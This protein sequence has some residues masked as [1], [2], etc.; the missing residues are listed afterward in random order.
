M[1]TR[2]HA[3][4]PSCLSARDGDSS[5]IF[6][7]CGQCSGAR[8]WPGLEPRIAR[9]TVAFR[10]SYA[11]SL[12]AAP[13]CVDLRTPRGLLAAYIV[14][15]QRAVRRHRSPSTPRGTRHTNKVPTHLRLEQHGR[16][17]LTRDWLGRTTRS[18]PICAATHP[19]ALCALLSPE[20]VPRPATAQ[21]LDTTCSPSL[22]GREGAPP[23]CGSP[24]QTSPWTAS[25]APFAHPCQPDSSPAAPSPTGTAAAESCEPHTCAL[26]TPNPCL[27]LFGA[28]ASLDRTAYCQC[29]RNPYVSAVASSLL[30]HQ[31]WVPGM[32]G[33]AV[34]VVQPF[35]LFFVQPLLNAYEAP[36]A[37][38]ITCLSFTSCHTRAAR[39]SSSACH[40]PSWVAGRFCL[41]RCS[42]GHERVWTEACSSAI[43]SQRRCA[44]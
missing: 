11:R 40:L 3:E 19:G 12:P 9:L 35:V 10:H 18:R 24:S 33:S 14:R 22:D 28:I 8:I 44:E 17:P 5:A 26:A 34:F 38:P 39:A 21:R 2:I 27:G 20:H 13:F 42:L 25:A 23:P 1:G 15:L 4:A 7:R 37:T 32:E 29:Q 30:T 43:R 41:A 36:E 31:G 6:A 16:S